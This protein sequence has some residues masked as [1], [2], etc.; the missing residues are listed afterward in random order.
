MVVEKL[1]SYGTLQL[2]QVQLATFARIL[3]GKKD[4]LVGYKLDDLQITDPYVIEVSGKSVHQILIPTGSERDGVD[5][6]VF[7]LNLE[8]L[9][10]A[11]SYEVKDYK[12]VRVR[13]AS[14]EDAWVYAHQ[15]T[16]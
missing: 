7:E 4:R 15:S 12:R 3:N 6:M 10:K 5:G 11:D 9:L 13:L 2:E 14:G 8:E 16:L 1:F